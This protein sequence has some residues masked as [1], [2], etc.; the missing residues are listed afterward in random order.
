MRFLW[1]PFL[2]LSCLTGGGTAAWS[3]DPEIWFNPHPTLDW[4]QMFSD[5]APWQGAASHVQVIE[6]VHWWLDT[7]TD[8][9]V[10]AIGAFAKSHHMKIDL[11]IQ[12]IGI[13]SAD[14]CG[15]MEGYSTIGI[16]TSEAGILKRNNI[17]PDMMTMDEPVGFGHYDTGT[18][19]C[20]FP[21]DVL[22][23][24]VA[25]NINGAI[26]LF[27]NIQ[28]YE[29]EPIPALTGNPDW[30]E[31]ETEFQ[32]QVRLMTGKPVRGMQL[33]I[34]WPVPAWKQAVADI[35]QFTHGRNMKW[36][37]I[38][39]PSSNAN[40]NADAVASVIQQY[41]YME[42]TMGIVPD[43][44][45][46]TSW[47]PYP[48][49][50]MPDT[51]P[52]AQTWEIAQYFRPRTLMQAHFVGQGARGKLTTT[53]GLPVAGGTI[54]GYV[55][56]VDFK[57]PLPVTVYQSVVPSNAVSAL[58]GIRLNIECGCQGVNDVL[59]GPIQYQETQ[60]GSASFSFL[61]PPVAGTF[62]GA[63]V[64]GEW[65][66][67]TLVARIITT[68]PT[69]I[70]YPNSAFFP[71]TPGARYNFTVP[72][73]TIGGEGWYG[74]VFLVWVDVNGNG[75]TREILVPGSGQR[76]MSTTTTAADGTFALPKLPRVGPGSAPVTI[77]YPGDATHRAVGWSPLR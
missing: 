66:G 13:T 3:A 20:L 25:A 34:G 61:F 74:N 6:V 29:I 47:T 37:P 19:G 2:A 59:V 50:S 8:A 28:L 62:N 23:A 69:Q 71:V 32:N 48:Q 45:I 49:Y 5:D 17:T 39:D 4:M 43:M 77:E 65:V 67:G 35:Q 9:Q 46:F 44:V 1:A 57:L 15:L 76:L 36:G 38:A 33:D 11:E 27:P 31:I 75:I 41:E 7:A 42:G 63:I 18:G 26:A 58:I 22:A 40:S 12:A 64:G 68:S 56:G 60:G 21:P 24:R 51:S 55:P 70:V 14:T 10:Q 52:G 73:S 16:L 72:A 54:N 30:R 53:D